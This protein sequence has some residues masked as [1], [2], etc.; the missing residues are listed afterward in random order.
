MPKIIEPK[1]PND[2]QPAIEI[3]AD[4]NSESGVNKV[5]NE[6]PRRVPVVQINDYVLNPSQLLDLSIF[7]GSENGVSSVPTFRMKVEDSAYLIQEALRNRKIDTVNISF[8]LRDWLIKFVGIITSMSTRSGRGILYLYGVWY[9][10][11]LYNSEQKLFSNKSVKDILTDMCDVSGIGLFTYD[12]EEI[13]K[14][15]DKVINPNTQ[16]LKFMQQLISTYTSNLYCFDVWGYLH[17]GNVNEIMKKPID[18]YSINQESTEKEELKD[19]VFRINK[20]VNYSDKD[21]GKIRVDSYSIT[22]NFSNSKTSLATKYFVVSETEAG[23]DIFE[24]QLVSDETIG[25]EDNEAENTFH[26]FITVPEAQSTMGHKYPFRSELIEK[27]LIGNKLEFEL[28]SPVFEITPYTLV[29]VEMYHE[30]T[31][32]R[33][34]DKKRVRKD[35]EH[36]GKYVVLSIEYKYQNNRNK[37]GSDNQIIQILKLFKPEIMQEEEPDEPEPVDTPVEN[38]ERSKTINHSV[39]SEPEE[40]KEEKTE[41]RRKPTKNLHVSQQMINVVKASEG[42]FLKAYKCPANIWTIG[43]GHT[44]GVREGMTITK[45]QAEQFLRQD[46]R[47]FENEIKRRVPYAT[48]GEFDALVDI[49]YGTGPGVF[50]KIGLASYHNNMSPTQTAKKITHTAVTYMDK[51]TKTRKVAQGLVTRRLKDSKLYL[52]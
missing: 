29:K 43:W 48:Q 38:A 42:C 1:I 27:Q 25:I 40:K 4:K 22:N 15:V 18:K 51:K 41:N 50:D 7:T 23:N 52:S 16:N 45:E 47:Y 8:G 35:K 17:V 24:K 20:R 31:S 5:L 6:W 30:S 44:T 9:N 3:Q 49:I 11:A 14:P 32:E 19:I 46:L 37:D 26:G 2:K 39:N 13:T 33:I 21:K 10:E 36:S 34:D 28:T 12:N